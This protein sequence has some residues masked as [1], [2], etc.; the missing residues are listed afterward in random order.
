MQKMSLKIHNGF[1]RNCN[2]SLSSMS[3]SKAWN[4]IPQTPSPAQMLAETQSKQ[5]TSKPKN[6]SKKYHSKPL[7]AVVFRLAVA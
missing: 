5:L 7:K 2:S 4:N 6:L 1:M 3:F